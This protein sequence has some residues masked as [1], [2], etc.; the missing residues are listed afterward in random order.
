MDKEVTET[1]STL[2]DDDVLYLHE[3]YV[4]TD[5]IFLDRNVVFDHV[6][7]E[8]KDY[9]KLTLSFEIP[10]VETSSSEHSS[11]ESDSA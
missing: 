2:A 8:W 3:N 6:D 11:A 1:G 7:E 4:V 5:S 10:T 9:C